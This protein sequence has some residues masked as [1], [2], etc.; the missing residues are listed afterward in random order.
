MQQ[1]EEQKANVKRRLGGPYAAPHAPGK[2]GNGKRD[3]AKLR[4]AAGTAPT[5]MEYKINETKKPAAIASKYFN[6]V[7]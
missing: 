2:K 5:S 4:K 3:F 1:R 6:L 7:N